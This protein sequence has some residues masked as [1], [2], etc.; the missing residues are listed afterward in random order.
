MHDPQI[1]V[2]FDLTRDER[3]TDLGHIDTNQSV[4]LTF[5]LF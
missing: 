5:V 4:L 2:Y 1:N 3:E